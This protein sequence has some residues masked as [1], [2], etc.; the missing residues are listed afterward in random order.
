MQLNINGDDLDV[1]VTEELLEEKLRSLPGEGD[2][3]LILSKNEMTYM[4][5]SGSIQEGFIL[6]YQE[7]SV[8][9]HYACTNSPLTQDLLVQAFK[10]Y[11]NGKPDWIN[12]L[13]WEKE[14]I[15]TASFSWLLVIV[16]LFVLAAI[17]YWF[18]S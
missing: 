16:V 4:Q 5:T 2:S 18:L 12:D 14:D 9:E 13:T 15:Q 11:L 6:E 10:D 8:D 3:F 7:G 17:A 1:V